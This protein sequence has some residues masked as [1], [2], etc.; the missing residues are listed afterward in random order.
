[1]REA[2]QRAISSI[3]VISSERVELRDNGR[4]IEELRR[5]ERRRG[6]SGKDSI[7]H[8]QYG[9]SDDLANAVAGMVRLV[10]AG[11]Y[12][13]KKHHH[14]RLATEAGLVKLF[15]AIRRSI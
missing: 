6:R 5:L 13:D 14:D 9:G 3:P 10:S 11:T 7:D 15:F 2:P 4:M 1:M 8:P 12:I